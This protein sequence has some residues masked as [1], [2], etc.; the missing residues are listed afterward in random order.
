[1]IL[2]DRMRVYKLFINLSQMGSMFIE[3]VDVKAL[4]LIYPHGI[5]ISR[6][7]VYIYWMFYRI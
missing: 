4:N 5:F 7:Y 2:K 6:Q 1:M 3:M